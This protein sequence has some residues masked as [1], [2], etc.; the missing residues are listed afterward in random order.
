[1][2]L[3]T[4]NTLIQNLPSILDSLQGSEQELNLDVSKLQE[5]VEKNVRYKELKKTMDPISDSN[6]DLEGFKN[7]AQVLLSCPKYEQIHDREEDRSLPPI[8]SILSELRLKYEIL[9]QINSL[10]QNTFNSDNFIKKLQELELELENLKSINLSSN[11][12]EFTFL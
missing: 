7:A 3:P 2:E 5:T 1:M 11:V 4:I 6:S 12:Q 10:E 9:A 8:S